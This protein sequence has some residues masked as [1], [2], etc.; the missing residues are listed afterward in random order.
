MPRYIHPL[1]LVPFEW[2]HH[3]T[4]YPPLLSSSMGVIVSCHDISTPTL[5]FHGSDYIMPRYIHPHSL[6][7]FEWLYHATIYPPLLSCS[8][9]VTV[10][11]HDISTPTL[12]FHGSDCI[13]PWYIHPF[14]LVPREWLYHATIYPTPLCSSIWVIISCHDIS[15]PTLWFHGRDYI[16]PWYIHP[17]SLVPWEWLYHAMI[18]PPLLSCSME[19]IISCLNIQPLCLAVWE[20]L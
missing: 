2:L 4:T 3:A 12:L 15:T 9:G 1:S 11:C 19:V 8:M 20:W 18:Y 14:S 7:P 16:M 17:H 13:M 6:V 10:S 5:L